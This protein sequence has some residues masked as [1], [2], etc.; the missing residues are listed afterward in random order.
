MAQSIYEQLSRGEMAVSFSTKSMSGLPIFADDG[1]ESDMF[2]LR[3]GD[4]IE[5]RVDPA[6]VQIG[7]VSA[8]TLFT[9]ASPAERVEQ[10]KAAGIPALAA[11][12][13]AAALANPYIQ[14]TFRVQKV[15]LG[16]DHNGGWEFNVDSIN[17][18]DVRNGTF[19]V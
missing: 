3:P 13:A 19:A 17:Y 6:D 12:Q 8:Y 18:L 16:W 5:I 7:L 14:T 1:I 4:A 9:R 2:R 11:T 10:M 15:G